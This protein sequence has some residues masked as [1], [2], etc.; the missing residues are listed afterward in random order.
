M[1]I[2]VNFSE[3]NNQQLGALSAKVENVEADVAEMKGDL[4]EVR[5]IMLKVQGSWKTLAMLSGISA[6]VGALFAKLAA[7]LPLW[8][9]K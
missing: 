7:W 3:Q 1:G 6:A 2:A 4:R 9:H 8:S 5:D